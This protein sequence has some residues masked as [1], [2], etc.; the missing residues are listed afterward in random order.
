M[1]LGRKIVA[2][3]VAGLTVGA[4]N[5]A[6]AQEPAGAP[7]PEITTQRDVSLTPKQML[8]EAEK[9]LPTMEQGASFVRK[10]LSDARE[11]KDVVKVLCL[12]DKLSQIDVA[13]R[14]ARDRMPNLRSAADRNDNDRGR[15]E[16]TVIQVLRDRVRALVAEA[17]QCIG[18]ET[19]FVGESDV[20][21]DI[22]PTIPDD[23]S[24]FPD[25]PIVSQPPVISSPTS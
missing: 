4:I 23:P 24:D 21:V 7:P 11:A 6:S 9:Y 12:N 22:D 19:G 10:Q 20:T 3:A 5:A 8:A 18:E 14:S 1:R 25:D 16:F 13:I 2:L 15:H 17:N